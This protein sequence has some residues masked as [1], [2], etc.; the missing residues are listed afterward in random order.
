M[1]KIITYIL[2]V[3]LGGL[4]I[5]FF[6]YTVVTYGLGVSV[7][8]I[9]AWKEILIVLLGFLLLGLLFLQSTVR[10][11]SYWKSIL[12]F[13]VLLLLWSGIVS[14]G[15]YDQPIT[16]WLV[17]I[18]Y[19]F[20]PFVVL[21]VVWWLCAI[22]PIW[23]S[24]FF[25]WCVGLLK[26]LLI[27]WLLWYLL[28]SL[29]PA[30]IEWLW[31]S[32]EVWQRWL[33]SEPPVRYLTNVW[34][35]Y[36]RNQ[37]VFGGP[38]SWWLYLL[39]FWPLFLVK[40]IQTLRVKG[41]SRSSLWVVLYV[42]SLVLSFSRV[43]WLLFVVESVIVLGFV[44]GRWT[45]WVFIKQGWKVITTL[46]LGV[47]ASVF[48]VRW[49][50][51]ADVPVAE[52]RDQWLRERELSD[53]GHVELF[54]EWVDHLTLS[55]IY[56]WGAWSAGP[57]SYRVDAATGSLADQYFF[58]TENQYLQIWVEWWWV[59]LFLY[60]VLLLLIIVCS[61]F[62]HKKTDTFGNIDQVSFWLGIGFVWLMAAWMLQHSLVDVQVMM[63]FMILLWVSLWSKA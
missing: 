56:G 9:R 29:V 2:K 63:S 25:V 59:G 48:L 12:T 5:H 13:L 19:D 22:K 47:A 50:W 60:L 14:F 28:I 34:R 36:I 30:W 31:Y 44:Y 16:D 1:D 35:W 17:A 4:A 21:L 18:R 26:V 54:L 43:V 62:P 49:L 23:A 52:N 61:L 53:K 57:A 40:G 33:E 37:W 45:W 38:V 6:V 24:K 39:V 46:C 32:R 27:V 20:F 3:L 8:R 55:P 10:L 7:W 51:P 15:V 42:V 41:Y 58:N 11:W